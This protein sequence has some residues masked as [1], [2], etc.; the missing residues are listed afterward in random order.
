MELFRIVRKKY[1]EDLSG[2]GAKLY[3]GRWNEIG[4]PCIYTSNNASLCLC[5]YLVN[6]PTYLLPSDLQLIQ[7]S[8][9]D[10]LIQYVEKYQL[11]EG[12]NSIP[13]SNA[14]QKFGSELLKNEGTFAFTVP[15]VIVPFELNIILNPRSTDFER[16]VK[17]IAVEAFKLDNRF[18][19]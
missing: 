1:A 8:I 10:N 2:E 15:S 17:V 16:K 12:W 7:Y 11:P 9:E 4:S 5:E 18:E 19:K 14:S 13:V 3:G 6:L